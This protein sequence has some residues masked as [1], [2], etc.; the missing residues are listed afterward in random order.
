MHIVNV[1][2][3]YRRDELLNSVYSQSE[4]TLDEGERLL[5]GMQELREELNTYGEVL[6]TLAERAQNVVPLKQRR[7]P[8]PRPIPV[9]AVCSYKQDNVSIFV[10]SFSFVNRSAIV[11]YKKGW[12]ISYWPTKCKGPSAGNGEGCHIPVTHWR[13]VL[14]T[15]TST[16]REGGNML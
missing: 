3:C 2:V 1:N 13:H 8:V 7:A 9:L 6:T 11:E 15:F 5:K 4:F 10:Y 16:S 14:G 12:D